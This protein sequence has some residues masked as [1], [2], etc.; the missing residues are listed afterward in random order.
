M[1]RDRLF[2]GFAVLAVGCGDPL[3]DGRFPG[4]PLITLAGSIRDQSPAAED[5]DHTA[6]VSSGPLKLAVFWSRGGLGGVGGEVSGLEQQAIARGI[7]PAEF[8]L[9]IYAP[10]HDAA[11]FDAAGGGRL[12]LGLL[13]AYVDADRDGRYDKNA[14]RVIGGARASALIYSPEGASDPQ[15]GTFGAGFH[16]VH[17]EVEGDDCAKGGYEVEPAEGALQIV[18]D[19]TSPGLA[20]HDVDCDG[21]LEGAEDICPEHGVG[22]LCPGWTCGS[23]T[24][25]CG[26]AFC[27]DLKD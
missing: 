17:F 20:L 10:P 5:D 1:T 25:T 23:T 3:A 27:C 16:R 26:Y 4:D 11:L 21:T 8:T 14:D 19:T 7:F 18:L 12:A 24:G 2:I 13:V 15:Y 6:Q 22:S 9:A